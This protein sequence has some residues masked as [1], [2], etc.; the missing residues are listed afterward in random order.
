MIR[1]ALALTLALSL[2][3]AAQAQTAVHPVLKAHAT[4]SGDLVKIGDLVENA[5]IVARVPSF[6]APDLGTTGT[7]S[8][9]AIADAVAKHA[10]LGLDTAGLSEVTVSRP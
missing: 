2:G 6:R 9:D 4:V 10:L 1:T 8:A 7:V 5:G 3:A